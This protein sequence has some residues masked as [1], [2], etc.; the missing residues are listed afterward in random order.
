MNAHRHA[1][2]GDRPSWTA[3][4][5]IPVEWQRNTMAHLCSV[6][7]FHADT[8]FGERGVLMG[9]NVTGGMSGFYFDPFEFYAQRHLTNPNMI[10]MGAVG[11]GKS[12]TVKALVRRLKA[13]YGT[14][15][16]LAIVDPKG[17]YGPLA[18]DLGLSVIKPYP[19][20]RDRINP[21]DAGGGDG[22][23]SLLARQHLAVQLIAGVLGR[24][25]TPIEDAVLGW[26][27]ERR[28]RTLLGVTLRDLCAEVSDPPDE[29][30]Q[31][32]RHSPHE[33]ARATAPVAFALDKLC[34]RTLRGMFD[35]ETTVNI[36]WDHGPG[37]VLDL[38]A[39]YGNSE[40]L[41]LVIAAATHWLS[42][43]LRGRSERRSVQVID[44]AWAAIRHGAAYFQS[45]LKLSRAHGVAT[46][47]VCHRPSDLTA[48]SDDG[49][50]AAKIAAGLLSDIQT[51]VLLRQP[52]EQI[53]AAAEMFDLTERERGWLAQLVP[54]R[55][56]WQIGAR[57]AVVQTILAGTE[58]SLFDTDQPM[59][60]VDGH[61][62]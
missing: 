59:G 9:A 25:L 53:P 19:G 62:A 51:R 24:D 23:S 43:A 26:A 44:E 27:I 28:S 8:G 55:A 17:E 13:V 50:A 21:M 47:L 48:Q 11:F 30:V 45:S 4:P 54:G 37:V 3:R 52:P 20:G 2:D 39:V 29:L 58:R 35:G 31:L 10:V 5:G 32:S 46:V 41:P 6:C 15:R 22:D 34:A 42:A 49:T 56:I 14:D 12:A 36:D 38:S 40:A 33:L 1:R 7:P 18:A 61:A 60:G 16:Y 57:S